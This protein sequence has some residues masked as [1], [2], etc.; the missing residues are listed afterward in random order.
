MSEHSAGR[1]PLEVVIE[2]FLARFRAGERPGIEEF[3]ARHPELAGPL[4]DLLPALVMVEQDLTVDREP[5]PRPVPLPASPLEGRLLGDYRIL[6]EVGRGGMGVVYEAEQVSLGRRV[7]IKVLPGHLAGDRTRLERFRREAKAAARLHHTNIVPVFEVG[8]AGGVAYYAMQ[9]IQGQGLDQVIAELARLRDPAGKARGPAES[10][11]TAAPG[12]GVGRVAA[13]LL[14][15]R[16]ASEGAPPPDEMACAA[17]EAAGDGPGPTSTPP[18]PPVALPGGSQA[19]PTYL[20]GRRVTYFRSVAQIGRQAAQGLAY[21]HAGG[22]IHRDIK[23]SN[24]LLDHAGVVWIAD[25]GLAKGDDDGLTQSGD[26]LGTLRYM[27]PERFRGQGDG[28][29]DVYALGMTLYE[30]LTLRPAFASD[31]RLR[32]IQQIK[33]EEPRRPRALDPRI[34]RDLE[35]IVLKAIEKDPR[36]RYASA[37]ALAEDLRR[38]LADEPIRARQVGASE[39]YWRWARRNPT[40]AIMGGVLTALLVAI[41]AGSLLAAS[42][43]ASLAAAEG[44]AR[45]EAETA[46]AT[47]RA[48]EREMRRLATQAEADKGTAQRETRRAEGEKKRAEEQLARAERLVYAGKLMLAQNDF[49]AGDGGLARHYLDEAQVGLR[50]WEHRYLWTRVDARQ[51]L[52]GHRNAVYGVAFSPDGS[53]IVTAG[54]DGTAR[55]W[56]AATGQPVLTF[57]GHRNYVLSVAFSPDGRRIVTG[58]GQWAQEA[59]PDVAK[60]WDAATGRELLTLSGHAGCIWSVAFSPD[61]SRIVSGS[62]PWAYGPGEAKVWDAA[63]GRELLT[64]PGTGQKVRSVAFSPDGR[65]IATGATDGEARAWDAATGRPLATFRK[66]PLQ[67][68]AFSPDGGRVV[69]AHLD[70]SVKVWDA[71]TGRNLLAIK[72]H[73]SSIDAVAFSPDG[74][75]LATGGEDQTTRVWDA[76]TGQYLFTLKGHSLRV[77]TLAFSP[78]GSRLVTGSY[79]GTAKVWDAATGQ[80]VPVLRGHSD[81]IA[82]LAFDPEGRRI[83]TASGDGTARVWDAATTRPLLVLRRSDLAPG[84]NARL[85][86]AAFSPDGSRIATG[87][88]DGTARVWDAATG[89]ELLRL[90]FPLPVKGV[91]F[92][93]DGSRLVTGTWTWEGGRSGEATVWDAATG[94]EL[95]AL[96]RG[97]AGILG[98]EFSPD[99]ARI[100]TGSWDHKARVYDAATGR[101]LLL[102]EGHSGPVT[103]VAFRR[104][105]RRILTGGTDRTARVWDAATGRELLG[106]AGHTAEV[107]GVAFSPDGSRVATVSHDRSAKLWDAESGQELLSLKGQPAE[108]LCVAFSPDGSRLVTG[109]AGA[110]ATASVW[111]A[112]PGQEVMV[113]RGRGE[114]LERVAFSPDS[115]RIFGW[116]ARKRVLAW[117]AT[118]GSPV[119]PTNPPDMPAPGPARSA[120]G[121]VQ[122]R[123][124]GQAIVVLDRRPSAGENAWPLRDRDRGPMADAVFPRDPFVREAPVPDSSA[125]T[126][127]DRA[128]ASRPGDPA[129]RFQRGHQLARRGEWRAALADYREGL[130]RDPSNSL[131]WM[132]AA[133]LYLQLGDGEGYRR[134]ARSMLDAFGATDDPTIAERTAK[135]GL[136]TP[137]PPE[138]A[139]RLIAL[140]ER[141]VTRGAGTSLRPWAQLARGMAAYRDGQFAAAVEILLAAGD[142]NAS[143]CITPTAALFRAMAESRLGHVEAARTRLDDA[144]RALEA[145]AP[146]AADLGAAWH[147]WLICQVALREA[148]A[149]IGGQPPAPVRPPARGR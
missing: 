92:S 26:I 60:V 77:V 75:R 35:T 58:G 7:A 59:R 70:G 131:A 31:D 63:T 37:E 122:A 143:P 4:R 49:E 17:T 148:E 9:F 20:S 78:D 64:L 149:V 135:I 5:R 101:E 15:G 80:E 12:A 43:F 117:S 6:R 119:A 40:I 112:G 103:S 121:F 41:T 45:D 127:L 110:N 50:G 84:A 126:A 141:A 32:L 22:I 8:T 71:A 132:G 147:D 140:A 18:G 136:L 113:L 36:A 47:A 73:R 52:V 61:G 105:G 96:R 82:S 93:P 30:L 146:P 72:G 137:P 19:T 98:V 120:D 13:S 83:V 106:L 46:T 99:G 27:A 90:S 14:T 48:A 79:D 57:S 1:D 39:R 11:P 21:A 133:T 29:T 142:A 85:S 108:L 10:D 116:D 86:D 102:L 76:A 114:R 125:D 67:S 130:A 129:P 95:L 24:L 62:G 53:R 91:A 144:R 51:T 124:E 134:H 33:E 42:R 65:R 16:I 3:A 69:T 115:G 55:V 54:Y 94:R 2:S 81:Y 89:R 28:R 56:D 100:V 44:K 74:R 109:L 138:D 34:P 107:R 87:G 123:P 139:P 97:D 111:S 128:I 23:P 104:D 66:G 145:I 118:D 88:E 68:L 38:F 25:F